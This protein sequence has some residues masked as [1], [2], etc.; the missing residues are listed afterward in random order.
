MV[1]IEPLV[2]LI[3]AAG[4][5]RRLKRVGYTDIKELE[6]Y[7]GVPVINNA[8][9]NLLSSGIEKLVIVVRE[10]KQDLVDHINRAYGDENIVFSFQDGP[11]GNL[12]DA[13]CAAKSQIDNSKVLMQLGDTA[14]KP[15]PFLTLPSSD[16]TL[17]LHCFRTT[18][19]EASLYGTIDTQNKQ[20][21]DKPTK[22]SSTL[23]WGAITWPADFTNHLQKYDQLTDALNSYSFEYKEN[24]SEYIDIGTEILSGHNPTMS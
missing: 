17:L 19:K 4:K 15:L 6:C 8:I 11:I 22:P 2:G 18:Q 21:I 3:P 20:V 5:A 24:I 10:G 14:L 23:C 12:R 1:N 9:E 16:K 7:A 13:I